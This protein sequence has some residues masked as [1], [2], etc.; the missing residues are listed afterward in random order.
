[1]PQIR[2]ETELRTDCERLA[3]ILTTLQRRFI[4]KLSLELSRGKLSFPQYF[5]LGF[6]SHGT[7]LTMSE[8]AAKMGH[9]T[10]AATGLVD[11]LENLGYVTR[12]HG[13][14]DRRKIR[15]RITR[16]GM[17]LVLQVRKDMVDNLVKMMKQLN[18]TEQKMWVQIYEKIIP[19]FQ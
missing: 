12:A 5:L 8:I 16:R 9:T 1:M 18:L 4:L 2:D 6:L 17:N 3:D 19:L 7:M 15:V 13:T 14:D 10:A 11:R